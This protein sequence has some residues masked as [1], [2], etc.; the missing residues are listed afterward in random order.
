MNGVVGAGCHPHSAQLC[1]FKHRKVRRKTNLDAFVGAH[2]AAVEAPEL[3]AWR[4]G[5]RDWYC[6]VVLFVGSDDAHRDF[7]W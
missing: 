6:K 5:L 3:A 4:A 2:S 7:T 1:G